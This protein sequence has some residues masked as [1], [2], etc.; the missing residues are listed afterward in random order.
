LFHIFSTVTCTVPTK[1]IFNVVVKPFKCLYIYSVLYPPFVRI[2]FSPKKHSATKFLGKGTKFR[3]NPDA[4]C[5]SFRLQERSKKCF[6]PNP[7]SR[8]CVLHY[9]VETV[10][11]WI[12]NEQMNLYWQMNSRT[13]VEKA[14]FL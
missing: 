1:T 12:F 5:K 11:F 9:T 2:R 3:E 4:C 13:K 14:F 6:R 7:N 8:Y 10:V